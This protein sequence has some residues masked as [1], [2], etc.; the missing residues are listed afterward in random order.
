MRVPISFLVAASV[1]FGCAP[2]PAVTAPQSA[3]AAEPAPTAA[4]APSTSAAPKAPEP[5]VAT[6][7]ASSS[8]IDA[9][10]DAADRSEDDR[11]L[12]E[13]RKPKELLA[14]C[15]IAPGMKVAELGAGGGYTTELL[16]RTVG[17][18]GHVWGQ[19]SQFLLGRFAEKPWSA[20]LEKPVL[21]NVTRSDRDFDDPL[22]PDAKQLDAV[23]IVLFYHDTV[24]QKVDRARM[25][26]AVFAALEPGGSYCVVDHSARAGSEVADV[27]TLHR[28]DEALVKREIEKAGFVLAAENAFLRNPADPRDWNASPRAAGERRGTSDRF[29][30][31]FQKPK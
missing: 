25:N 26:R 10:V 14:F 20:R 21:G 24:W 22:P 4:P 28:I 6:A 11:A 13:G 17:P 31:R 1:A 9:A 23:L 7:A 18:S 30:L 12:D 19:N 15:G 3:T 29:A 2:A 8:P 27:Q 5:A 16:A